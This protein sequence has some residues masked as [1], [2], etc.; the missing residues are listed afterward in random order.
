[1]AL[2]RDHTVNSLKYLLQNLNSNS[3]GSR[4]FQLFAH[5]VRRKKNTTK[6]RTGSTLNNLKAVQQNQPPID[7]DSDELQIL[8][9]VDGLKDKLD[10][11]ADSVRNV[12]RGIWRTIPIES[13]IN[14][15]V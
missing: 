14:W 2:R 4:L 13:Q 11:V 12:E 15:K 1:M 9:K 3:K 7:V 6:R 8:E 10:C 5:M